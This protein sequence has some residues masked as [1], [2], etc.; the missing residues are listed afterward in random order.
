MGA[1]ALTVPK[2]LHIYQFPVVMSNRPSVRLSVHINAAP[3]GPK[4]GKFDTGTVIRT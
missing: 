1:A 4:S 2:Y 3:T